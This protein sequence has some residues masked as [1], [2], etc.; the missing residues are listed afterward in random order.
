MLPNLIV[1]GAAKAGTTSLHYYLGLHP[2]ISMSH[3]KE[4]NFFVLQKNWSKGIEWYESHFTGETEVL[5]ESSPN[6]TKHPVFSGVPKRMH[7]VVPEAKL[8]YILRDPIERIVS[9]YAYEFMARRENRGIREALRDLEN[10]HYV[11]CSQYHMQLEQYLDYFP[12]S[13]ILIMTLEDLSRRPQQT[14]QE[15]FRFLEVDESFHSPNFSEARHRSS[16]KRRINQI[17]LLW[18]RMPGKNLIKSL[19]PS[20]TYLSKTFYLLSHRK[21]KKPILDERLKQELIDFLKDDVDRL[22]KYTS[23]DFEYWCL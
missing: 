4:L 8:I 23:N 10:N 15:V 18:A 22:R 17:G 12:E 21:F 20:S 1:I 14:L 16:D 5:G 19:F 6:Y 11:A 3:P 9:H 13:N 2:Q 7:S